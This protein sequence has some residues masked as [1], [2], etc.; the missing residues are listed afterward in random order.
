MSR[1]NS[2]VALV[3]V[4]GLDSGRLDAKFREELG[5]Q[6]L[7]GVSALGFPTPLR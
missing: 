5:A 3:G 1:R 6:G 2:L 7:T 4:L